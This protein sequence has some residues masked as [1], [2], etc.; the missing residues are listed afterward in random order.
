MMEA[1]ASEVAILRRQFPFSVA[2]GLSHRH[3]A[4]ASW[5]RGYCLNPRLHLLFRAATRVLEPI[6]DLNHIFG[7]LGDWFYIHGVHRRPVILT[8]AVVNSPVDRSLL[9]GIDRFVVEHASAIDDLQHLGIDKERISLIFPAVDGQRFFPLE[10]RSDRFTVLFA[11]S[12][13]TEDWLEARGVPQILEAAQ[14]RP[15]MRFRLLWR[16][17]GNSAARARKLIAEKDLKNVELVVRISRDMPGEYN[18]AHVTVATFTDACRSKPA[19]NSLVESM[20]CGRPV[21][22]TK[23]VGL[24]DI[25]QESGAGIVCEPV[26]EALAEAL[27]LLSSD[28]AAY[29]TAA[30]KAAVTHF[31]MD[32]FLA[33]YKAIYEE[34]LGK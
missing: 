24:A 19:P 31:G 25:I 14:L 32:R 30:R 15:D 8:T 12:P 3:W 33:G 34:V 26:G 16:P 20:A 23:T 13:D 4:L 1:V 22:V 11:S 5:K 6:F 18:D 7:S 2:W 29:S 27:D 21:V 28:W 17:W 10:A 9:Q